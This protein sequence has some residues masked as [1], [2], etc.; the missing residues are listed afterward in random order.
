M[1]NVYIYTNKL[2]FRII[3]AFINSGSAKYLSGFDPAA[4]M[5]QLYAKLGQSILHIFPNRDNSKCIISSDTRYL[6]VTFRGTADFTDSSNLINSWSISK[7]IHGNGGRR[8]FVERLDTLT[9]ERGGVARILNEIANSEKHRHKKIIISGHSIGAAVAALFVVQNQSPEFNKKIK[10]IFLYGCPN[11]GD[12]S[13]YKIFNTY[14][15]NKCFNCINENDWVI[16]MHGFNSSSIGR[17][18]QLGRQTQ[19]FYRSIMSHIPYN[20]AR[21]IYDEICR[22][23]PR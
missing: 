13:F 19:S 10:Y 17:R 21:S 14:F 22:I 18:I 3:N 2:L 15:S 16:H 12:E 4:D 11:I 1:L 6:Y 8:G 23:Q 5:H 20:Y 7:N 9:R